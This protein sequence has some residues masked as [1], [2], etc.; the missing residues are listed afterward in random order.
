M[1]TNIELKWVKRKAEEEWNIF[2]RNRKGIS[3]V[4]S[5]INGLKI[6]LDFL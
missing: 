3:C 2:D 6:S 5:L 4:I 1:C